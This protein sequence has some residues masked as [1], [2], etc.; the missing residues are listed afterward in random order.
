MR[1]EADDDLRCISCGE[2]GPWVP[3]TE[4]PEMLGPCRGWR[5]RDRLDWQR[6]EASRRY[7]AALEVHD[8]LGGTPLTLAERLSLRL[9]LGP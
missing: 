2:V 9:S 4:C 3:G 8:A 1:H 6:G 7:A 5:D